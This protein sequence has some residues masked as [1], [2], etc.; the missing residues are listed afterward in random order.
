[1]ESGF[2]RQKCSPAERTGGRVAAW[3]LVRNRVNFAVSGAWRGRECF[4]FDV[5]ES[6]VQPVA[7]LTDC[8]QEEVLAS[9]FCLST[10]QSV[11]FLGGFE[12]T[13]KAAVE[14]SLVD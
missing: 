14:L 2:Q 11:N 5:H 13:I 4:V 6:F 9:R 12:G 7:R 3:L 8:S 10:H 1:M